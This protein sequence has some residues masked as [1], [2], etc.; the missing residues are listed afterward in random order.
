M[1]TTIIKSIGTNSRDYATITLAT[2]D[3]SNILTGLDMVAN[4]EALIFELYIDGNGSSQTFAERLAITDG[5]TTD[6]TRNVTFRAAAGNLH[7]GTRESGVRIKPLAGGN[8]ITVFDDHSRFE[9]IEIVPGSGFSNNGVKLTTGVVGVVL[10][11]CILEG[12]GSGDNRDGLLSG[13]FAV[14]S[15]SF[16]IVARNCWFNG[17]GNAGVYAF[18]ATGGATDQY[19]DLVNCTFTKC[20]YGI[21]FRHADAGANSFLQVINCIGGGNGTA[22]FRE[23][24]SGS[25][26]LD[27]TGSLTNWGEYTTGATKFPE[28]TNADVTDSTAA[29]TDVVIVEDFTGTF[30][31][32]DLRLVNHSENDCLLQGTGPEAND[33]V[34][35]FDGIGTLRIGHTTDPGFHQISDQPSSMLG[36]AL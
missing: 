28:N 21:G 14:G 35:E 27:T 33:L 31:A 18:N 26:T 32:I 1:V 15:S 22:D 19:F 20:N 16:P 17:F 30:S 4:D 34:T 8:C 36:F 6:V 10:E 3:V 29:G 23:I 12:F 11:N 2:A 5:L 25:G 9:N 24:V 7:D 13:G